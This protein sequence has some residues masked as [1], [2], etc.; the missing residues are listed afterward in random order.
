MTEK[1]GTSY[2]GDYYPIEAGY[3]CNYS[4][5]VDMITTMNIPGYDSQSVPV[6]APAI[7]MLKVLEL[8]NIILDDGVYSLFPV[9][10]LTNMED[11]IVADTSRFFYKDSLGVYVKALKLGDGTYLK[12][13]NPVYIK[14]TLVVGDS[15]E[16]AP[17]MDMTK[18]LANELGSGITQ[19][20]VQL[21]AEAKFFVVGNETIDLPIGKRKAMRLEQANDIR[22][23]G[24]MVVEGTP[25]TMNMTAE[26]AVIYH[27]IPD[28]GIVKQNVTGPLNLQASAMGET[29]TISIEINRCELGLTGLGTDIYDYYGLTKSIAL[30]SQK[31][32]LNSAAE[33]KLWKISQ[34]VTKII[35]R[36]MTIK[37]LR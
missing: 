27:L 22:L 1:E 5:S 33:Q 30:A 21:N 16:T 6:N 32:V 29:M 28:T 25:V 2:S 35:T 3:I 34:A 19:T 14:S 10:D 18:M 8:K 17:K 15:W 12:V 31:P 9:V 24:S 11:Q 23:K 26:L 4:G 13:T 37:T 7:G 20:D 36:A